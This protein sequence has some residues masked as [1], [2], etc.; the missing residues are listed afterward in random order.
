MEATADEL[1]KKHKKVGGHRQFEAIVIRWG[2][3]H[4]LVLNGFSFDVERW[5]DEGK[6]KIDIWI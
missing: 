5:G 3:C 2:V 1:I 6:T 4:M